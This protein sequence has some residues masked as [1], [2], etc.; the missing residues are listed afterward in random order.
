MGGK[1][2]KSTS[3]S[4][5]TSLEIGSGFNTKTGEKIVFLNY[6]KEGETVCNIGFDIPEAEVLLAALSHAI[7]AIKAEPTGAIQ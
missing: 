1:F 7:E 6:K 3:Q 2:V 5:D 4:E